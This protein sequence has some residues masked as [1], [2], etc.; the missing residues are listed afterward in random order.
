MN[1]HIVIIFID[2]ISGSFSV[3]SDEVAVLISLT[4][5]KSSITL[6]FCS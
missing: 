6:G 4:E 3:K 2:Y 1:D 5:G